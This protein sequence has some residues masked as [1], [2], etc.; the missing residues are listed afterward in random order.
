MQKYPMLNRLS[1][2]D[3]IFVTYLLR[4]SDVSISEEKPRLNVSLIISYKRLYQS[5]YK[6]EVSHA[7]FINLPSYLSRSPSF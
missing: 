4:F 7:E 1:K 5:F 3:D 2:D 6:F